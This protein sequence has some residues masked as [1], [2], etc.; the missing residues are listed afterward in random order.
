MFPNGIPPSFGVGRITKT[1]KHTPT[2]VATLSSSPTQLSSTKFEQ[3]WQTLINQYSKCEFTESTDKL[4]ALEGIVKV[5]MAARPDDNYAAG[6]WQ[7]TALFGLPWWRDD[8]VRELHPIAASI[9][10]APSW[11]WASVDGEVHFPLRN[12]RS[13]A[14]ERYAK[15][16]ALASFTTT[17]N[18][19]V[20]TSEL[21]N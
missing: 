14:V 16:K 15:V 7:S 11:S 18:G 8:E 12:Y 5:I 13:G 20:S 6:M 3:Y 9:G 4:L 1:L 17:Q 21:F 19:D 10:H 2:A